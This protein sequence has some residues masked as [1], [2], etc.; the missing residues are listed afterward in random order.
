MIS[1]LTLRLSMNVLVIS[2]RN[3]PKLSPIDY[4]AHVG[5]RNTKMR[6]VLGMKFGVFP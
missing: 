6:T 4:F 1:R 3:M 5:T 2:L